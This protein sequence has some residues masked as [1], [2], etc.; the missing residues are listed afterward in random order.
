[1]GRVGIRKI[2][3]WHFW[4]ELKSAYQDVCNILSRRVE[5]YGLRKSGGD[6]GGDGRSSSSS[7][8]TRSSTPPIPTNPFHDAVLISSPVNFDDVQR[9]N[10]A[11]NDLITSGNPIST[12]TK[13]YITFLTKNVECLQT[14]NISIQYEN[15]QLKIHVRQRKHQLSG[16][17]RVIDGKHIITAAVM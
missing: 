16:K 14:V 2:I 9:A 4:Y 1:M 17:R 12:P 5:Y 13:E 8:Q 3:K 6:S 11:L 7:T 15:K 10:I